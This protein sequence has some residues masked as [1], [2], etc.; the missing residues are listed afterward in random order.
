MLPELVII[1]DEDENDD[2]W[3]AFCVLVTSSSL[4]LLSSPAQA[5][6]HSLEVFK[7][8]CVITQL[9]SA[10]FT[11]LGSTNKRPGLLVSTNERPQTAARETA[12]MFVG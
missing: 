9:E 12:T 11:L 3:F 5:L 10:L 4:S 8:S 1:H 2:D 6:E 7:A